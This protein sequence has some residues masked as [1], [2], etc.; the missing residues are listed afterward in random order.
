MSEKEV[1][2]TPEGLSKLEQELEDLKTVKR[3]EVAARIKEAI[4]FGDISENSEY[5]EAKNEQAFIEGRILTLEKMLRNARII[6]N[7]DVDTGV[8]SVGSRVKLKD[9]EF[10][11]VVDYTIVGSAE[12]DPMNNKISNESPVG[13][14]LLGKAK[15]AIVDVNVPAGVIQYEILDINL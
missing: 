6:T 12:S 10:G 1:I 11:D 5:E 9:L 14:A 4:S 3:K 15:G 13:Q 8:V 7:E 2:L